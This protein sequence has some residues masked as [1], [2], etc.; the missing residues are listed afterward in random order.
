M[1]ANAVH[2]DKRVSDFQCDAMRSAIY[3]LDD[4]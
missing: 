2:A 1:A 4:C 3:M